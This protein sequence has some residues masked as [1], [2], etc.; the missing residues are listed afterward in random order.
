MPIEI[1]PEHIA[2]QIAAGEVVEGP[3]SI[4]KELVEN[5]ID[6]KATKI[7][8]DIS[9]QLLKIQV[10]DNGTGISPEDLPLA[11]KR[12][13][14][15]KIKTIDDLS[16]LMTMGFRGEALASIAAVSKLTCISKRQEDKHASKFYTENG[17]EEITITGASNGT[18]IIVDDLF[19]NTPARLKFLK[20][21]TKERGFIIDT[22]RSLAIANPQLA[23]SL[24][25]DGKST[26]KS[27]GSGDLEKC[28]AEIFSEELSDGLIKVDFKREEI[29]ISGY[30]SKPHLNRSDKRGIFTIVN[31]RIL[32]CFIIKSAIEA[33]YKDLLP[34]GKY[35][36]AVIKLNLPQ[37][38]I[39]VNVHPNKKEIKYSQT[40]KIYAAIGDAVAK[41]L[42]DHRYQS[43]Q[44]FQPSIQDYVLS[45]NQ[46]TNFNTALVENTDH[47][48]K[49]NNR[50]YS[51][52]LSI[53]KSSQEEAAMA[54]VEDNFRD[55]EP[56]R[57]SYK[58]DFSFE[59]PGSRLSSSTRKFVSRLGSVDISLSNNK[60]LKTI[61]SELGNKTS[62]ELVINKTDIEESLVIRGEFIGENWLKDKYLKLLHELGEEI[63]ERENLESNF[64]K[65]GQ[66]FTKSRPQA[67]PS[68]TQLEEI[69]Q[70]DHYTCVYCAK[71]LLHPD[72]VKSSL[73]ECSD[74]NTLNAHLASYDHHLPASKFPELNKDS[75]NLYACCIA[76]NQKKSNS[77][78]SQ[79]WTPNPQDAWIGNQLLIENLV[80]TQPI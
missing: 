25:I 65:P 21:S 76:C 37:E 61:I 12:H 14:T 17:E 20:S 51:S 50:D 19:F 73:K 63:L 23:F 2:N 49:A 33:V 32:K 7:N 75:R 74:P 27:S 70:R 4:I 47:Y 36:I 34:S 43:K 30:I 69:W 54:I 26:L 6:A 67:K 28:L 72:L 9:K 38:D 44:S 35:P 18:N 56:R 11:F 55:L 42:A 39:D 60:G 22:V 79:T 8:I 15:S 13:A 29:N 3:S 78:A 24:T 53:L 46:S 80:F 52:N 68:L 31:G 5:S 48:T 71:L 40:N 59:L 64:I 57:T 1:L 62:F 16:K 10:V 45:Q 58:D 77:L 66:K 41:T